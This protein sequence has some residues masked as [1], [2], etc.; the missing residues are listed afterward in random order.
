M[1]RISYLVLG[2]PTH[3]SISLYPCFTYHPQIGM[4]NTLFVLLDG[5]EDHPNPQMGGRKP[6]EVAEMPFLHDRARFRYTTTGRGYTHLFL[7]EF[8]TGH[9]PEMARAAIEAMGL[10]LL[11][12][13][14][15]KRTAY[16]LSPAEIKDGM[17]HWSYH[18]D[19]FKDRLRETVDRNLCIL[20]DYDPQIRYFIGGRAILTL[21]SDYVPELPGPPVDT[22]VTDIPGT[23]G[24]FIHRIYDDMGGVTDYPWGC[25]KFGKQYPPVEGLHDLFAVSDSPTALGVCA[26]LGFDF[27][28]VDEVEDRFIVAKEELEH[29]DVFIHIDEVDE[30]S[31]QKDPFKKKDILEKTD[32]LMEKYFSDTENII[33]FVDHGT[34]SLTGEHILM[35]VPLWTTIDINRG[36]EEVLPLNTLVSTLLKNKR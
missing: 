8:F 21:E 31:H 23:L 19:D 18:T 1:K 34:S 32:R 3:P 26:S 36:S 11:D 7:N 35:N 12:I 5:A 15:P 16:R 22:P 30:Y 9:P 25:G 4:S 27:K 10:G 33:Y 17:V 14:D 13:K 20:K 24:E 2:W 28:L 6:Y 29:R